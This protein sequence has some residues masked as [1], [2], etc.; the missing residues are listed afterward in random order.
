MSRLTKK[1][2]KVVPGT[3]EVYRVP[4]SGRD[5]WRELLE[6]AGPAEAAEA[7]IRVRHGLIEDGKADVQCENGLIRVFW[8]EGS[9]VQ[10]GA[11]Y[12][13]QCLEVQQV[14]VILI[15]F[16]GSEVT[17]A[18]LREAEGRFVHLSA[19]TPAVNYR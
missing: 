4:S 11:L 9:S 17:E 16:L 3:W 10:Y 18:A 14:G 1:V 5:A 8:V 15:F 7:A 12:A 2:R 19:S 6:L 13:T